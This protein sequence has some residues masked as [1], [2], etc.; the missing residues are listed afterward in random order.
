M[1]RDC[2]HCRIGT[3]P[4]EW[5]APRGYS[6]RAINGKLYPCYDKED[7]IACESDECEEVGVNKTDDDCWLCDECWEG[8]TVS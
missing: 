3:M 1:D 6:H 2:T 8:L 5:V 7:R 4:R